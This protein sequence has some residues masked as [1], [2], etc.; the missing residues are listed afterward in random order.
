MSTFAV[1]STR[2]FCAL[3]A[4]KKMTAIAAAL[5][6]ARRLSMSGLGAAL[7]GGR[8]GGIAAVL[9]GANAGAGDGNEGGGDTKA[10]AAV[11]LFGKVAA[12]AS[13]SS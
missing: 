1:Y 4:A 7:M 5:G 10:P 6:A 11:R 8:S 2:S 13:T 3:L 9:P 12:K